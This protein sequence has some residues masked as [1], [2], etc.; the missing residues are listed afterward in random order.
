MFLPEETHHANVMTRRQ[1]CIAATAVLAAGMS[2]CRARDNNPPTQGQRMDKDR[3]EVV[4]F[5]VNLKSYLDRPIFDVY[6]NGQDIGVAGGHP[7]G[8][9]GGLMTGVSVPLGPQVVTWRLGGPEG[10]PGNG[11]TV[12]AV[13]QPVLQ[14]PDAKLGYLGV[15]IYPDNTVELIPEAFWPEASKRGEEINRLWEKTN[16]K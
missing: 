14:R 16:G 12:K 1:I 6:L 7:H 3:R 10:M 13:N 15:H 9:A 5:D 11:D 8:G 4:Q 2:A